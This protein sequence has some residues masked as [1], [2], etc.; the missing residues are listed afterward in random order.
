MSF[1]YEMP[2]D[3]YDLVGAEGGFFSALG[4]I[5]R[6]AASLVPGGN[7][8][9]A[10]FDLLDGDDDDEPT[11]GVPTFLP[12]P[13]GTNCN[14]GLVFDPI[15]R[16]C[17]SP[18]S[19][20]DISTG[21]PVQYGNAVMGRYGAALTPATM[22]TVRRRCPRGTVLGNDNLCY[23][24]RDLR[25]NERKW[26][27]GGKPLFTG[28]DLNAITRAHN[29]EGKAKEIA[30][31]LGYS[32]RTKAAAAAANAKAKRLGRGRGGRQ[33]GITVIDTD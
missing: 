1:D 19:P 13:Q 25:K 30:E 7:I 31:K 23:N 33:Q 8:I 24:K 3:E 12:T 29:L 26:V 16:M 11:G 14:P 15:A 21:G 32:V 6:G 9:A 5:A 20:A 18:G 10:G 17:V 4:S 28:G 27:P 22:S 2:L